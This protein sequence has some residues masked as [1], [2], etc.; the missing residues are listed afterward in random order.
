MVKLIV[1]KYYTNLYNS[2]VGNERLIKNLN[3]CIYFP[4]D[5]NFA[6]TNFVLLDETLINIRLSYE[7][8]NIRKNLLCIFQCEF[9]THLVI[10]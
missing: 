6:A 2:K 4:D 9:C 10:Y 7:N 3:N 1:T 5:V 8:V